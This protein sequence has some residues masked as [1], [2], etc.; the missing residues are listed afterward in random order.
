MGT[1][2]Q[3]VTYD[4][5]NLIVFEPPDFSTLSESVTTHCSIIFAEPFMHKQVQSAQR[6]SLNQHG[7]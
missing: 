2:A 6:W 3:A 4:T 5:V 7:F 1:T